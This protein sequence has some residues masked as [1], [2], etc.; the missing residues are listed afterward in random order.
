MNADSYANAYV[1]LSLPR[2][3]S[4]LVRFCLVDWNPFEIVRIYEI[5]FR[6]YFC[7]LIF[8]LI[9]EN[10]IE[11]LESSG[12]FK[13]LI[14]LNRKEILKELKQLDESKL[15]GNDDLLLIPNVIEKTLLPR[16]VQLVE[17]IYDP[18][19]KKQTT[20]LSQLVSRL[21]QDYPTLNHKSSNTKVLI[22]N[23]SLSIS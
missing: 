2:L 7:L 16:L 18:M 20:N 10:G 3:F 14:S 23:K 21:I 19:S 22:L 15:E 13:E 4:P 11:Y 6:N 17:T 8:I 1:S 12:W 9:K 5:Q